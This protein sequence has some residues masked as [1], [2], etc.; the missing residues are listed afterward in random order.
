MACRAVQ[1]S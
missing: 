1:L